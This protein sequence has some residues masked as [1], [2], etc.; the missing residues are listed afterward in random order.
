MKGFRPVED[1]SGHSYTGKI[2]TYAVK[3][4]H[5]TRLA[6]GDLVRITG[7]ARSSDGTPY[8]DAA[9]AAQTIT[10]VIVGVD[11][12]PSSL[13]QTSLPA[14]TAGTVK[15]AVDKDL[16]L[17]AEITTAITVNN[18]GENCDIVATAATLTG[19]LAF[20]NMTLDTSSTVTATA[21][22]RIQALKDGAVAA[23]STVYCS[24]NESTFDTVGV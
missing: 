13:E 10:G 18:V 1:Y 5:S 17:E 6:V 3:S 15:V 4:T 2:R 14:S 12:D 19:G 21:Q 23:N 11:F 7:E 16:I 20:S 8:V 9:A 22:M 24:I